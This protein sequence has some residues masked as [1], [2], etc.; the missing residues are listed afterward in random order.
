MGTVVIIEDEF[1]Q[2][3]VDFAAALRLRGHR[4]VRCT[5]APAE[6]RLQ[7]RW[8]A[9]ADHVVFGSVRPDG[10]LDDRAVAALRASDV[11][12]WQ[13]AEACEV[14]V[15][16]RGI[17]QRDLPYLRTHPLS[18]DAVID[19]GQLLAHLGERGV[20]VPQSWPELADV[21]GG[22][23][24]PFI[25]KPRRAAG[26][27]G[28]QVVADLVAARKALAGA[29]GFQVQRFH[30]GTPQDSAGVARDGEVIDLLTY[31]NL[32]NPAA[33]FTAAYGIEAIYDP[34][35]EALTRRVVAE[36]GI[37]GPF[38]LDA[39]PDDDGHP[40]VID[41]NVRIFGCWTA[42]QALGMDVLGAYEYALGL[43]P[44]PDRTHIPAGARADIL[45]RPPLGVSSA[46]ERARWLQ[47]DSREIRRRSRWLGRHWARAALRDSIGWAMRGEP[48][49]EQDR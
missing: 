32:T 47:R 27:D 4:T 40:L 29:D 33:P 35:L 2:P 38:A 17:E 22:T 30:P 23:A 20:P 37:T 3:G 48:L 10:S 39:V 16:E 11:L 36:L 8:A 5:P 12:D 18:P 43:G 41:V 31:R 21:P 14:W 25:L 13:A 28:V 44:R 6:D 24:G 49:A 34:Q 45:R 19:K 7:Q 46:S 26:G 1:W 42:C 15:C 9:C